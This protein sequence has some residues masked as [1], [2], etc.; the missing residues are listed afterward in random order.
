MIGN[1]RP[2]PCI[3]NTVGKHHFFASANVVD[4]ARHAA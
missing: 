1:R 4:T 3:E 2:G